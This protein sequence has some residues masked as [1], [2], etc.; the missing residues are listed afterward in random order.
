MDRAPQ[1]DASALAG[2][3]GAGAARFS[4]DAADPARRP[5]APA[6]RSVRWQHLGDGIRDRAC[7]L[8]R[9]YRV[10]H[11]H[12][13]VRAHSDRAQE[14]G[15]GGSL[16]RHVQSPRLCGSNLKGD[17]ARSQSRPSGDGDDLRHRS[18]QIDQRPLRPSGRRRDPQIVH[19]RCGE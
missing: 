2:G 16:D 9:R 6:R 13:G 11:F 5:P 4:A 15:V 14:R 19:G 7:A 12:A 1:D 17:R 18:F 8:C 3:R 10:R